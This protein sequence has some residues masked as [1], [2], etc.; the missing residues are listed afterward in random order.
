[1]KFELSDKPQTVTYVIRLSP[2][3]IQ[4][5]AALLYPNIFITAPGGEAIVEKAELK[6][7]LKR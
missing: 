3:E 6:I 2:V 7:R 1:M 5:G 4:K